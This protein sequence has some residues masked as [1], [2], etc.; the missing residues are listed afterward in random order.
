MNGLNHSK[1]QSA[2]DPISGGGLFA[3]QMANEIVP[4]FTDYVR[5]GSI[6]VPPVWHHQQIKIF[7]VTNQLIDQQQG[8]RR[9]DIAIQCTIGEDRKS[10]RLNSSHVARSY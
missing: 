7:V 9:M 5:F 8:H 6:S 3:S 2:C 10:T 4:R 1:G